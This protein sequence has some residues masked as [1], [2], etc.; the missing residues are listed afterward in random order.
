[1][2]FK[3]IENYLKKNYKFVIIICLFLFLIMSN[4]E[5]F[6]TEQALASVKSTEQK[7]N[8]IFSDIDANK[9]T[10]KKVLNMKNII[11]LNNKEIRLRSD[12][13]SNHNIVWNSG[14]DGPE[15]KGNEGISLATSTGGAKR[16]IEIRKNDVKINANLRVQGRGME[17]LV[18]HLGDNIK[19]IIKNKNGGTYHKNDWICMIGGMNLDWS[20]GSPGRIE[21]FCYVQGDHWHIRSEIE[22]ENDKGRYFITCIPRAFFSRVDHY[23]W[24]NWN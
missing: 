12:G 4:K 24:I 7:V 1:M 23:G 15:I 13:D 22:G 10:M 14:V 17:L 6:T 19:Q 3:N 18:M 16:V 20:G 2:N 9:A 21:A 5:D 11:A 8:D